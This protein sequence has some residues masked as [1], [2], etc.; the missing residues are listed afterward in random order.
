MKRSTP[1]K[2]ESLTTVVGA[3]LAGLAATYSYFAFDHAKKTEET[4]QAKLTTEQKTLELGKM[5]AFN[6]QSESVLTLKRLPDSCAKATGECQY[7][8]GWD[9][10]LS[11]RGNLTIDVTKL[12]LSLYKARLPGDTAF[13]DELNPPW[14]EKGPI[15]WTKIKDKTYPDP[16]PAKTLSFPKPGQPDHLTSVLPD[17]YAAIGPMSPADRR[18]G[19][20]NVILKDVP[21]TWIYARGDVLLKAGDEGKLDRIVEWDYR[22]LSSADS[23]T[24]AKPQPISTTPA[25]SDAR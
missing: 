4:I 1:E 24:S 6:V 22:Q 16:E 12:A 10:A 18:Y 17:D 5:S 25:Q 21:A 19:A 14:Q 20:M 9:I 15:S 3:V 11:N 2:L 8:V 7:L 13:N 23:T